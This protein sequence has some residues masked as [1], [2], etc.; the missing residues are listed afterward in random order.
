MYNEDIVKARK[1]H[2]CCECG[3]TIAKGEKYQVV[4]GM[5]DGRF[6]RIKTCMLCMETRE[7]ATEGLRT[8]DCC[9]LPAFGELRQY[10]CDGLPD[11]S[12]L[13][14]PIHARFL[15]YKASQVQHSAGQ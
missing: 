10:L 15:A 11:T 9:D 5:W 8:G 13:Y 7:K 12:E 3:L 14:A 2:R 6:D 4:S 1:P